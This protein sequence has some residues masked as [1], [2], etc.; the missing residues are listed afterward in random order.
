[1]IK[2]DEQYNIT[3]AQA[4][5]FAQV[6]RDMAKGKSVQSMQPALAKAQQEAIESQYEELRQDLKAYEEL[7]NGG[8]DHQRAKSDLN[9]KH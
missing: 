8:D 1:M 2:N 7:R 4:E 3:K 6:L 9:S 5:K